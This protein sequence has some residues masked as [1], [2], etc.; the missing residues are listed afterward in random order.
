M[1]FPQPFK[2]TS[3]WSR[4]HCFHIIPTTLHVVLRKIVIWIQL[5]PGKS[6]KI[7]KLIIL[8]YEATLQ[9]VYNICMFIQYMLCRSLA[10]LNRLRTYL[11]V[12]YVI[13]FSHEISVPK[14]HSHELLKYIIWS[15]YILYVTYV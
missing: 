14:G 4:M 1:H 3:T 7:V 8:L 5:Y 10:G 12:S 13:L 6:L 15:A 9:Y 2:P 11:Y